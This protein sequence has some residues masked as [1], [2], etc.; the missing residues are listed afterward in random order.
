[1]SYPTHVEKL[2]NSQFKTDLAQDIK[3]CSKTVM[4]ARLNEELRIDVVGIAKL[5]Y[6]TLP[7]QLVRA[8]PWNHA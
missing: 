2:K 1:V 8:H 3:R 6:C 5:V 4:K 7:E